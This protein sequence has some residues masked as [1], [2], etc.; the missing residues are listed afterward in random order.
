MINVLFLCLGNICR[1]PM[2]EAIFRQTVKEKGVED[3]ILIDSA[4]L[5]DWHIGHPPHEGTR[6][7]LDEANISYEGQKARQ[8][9]ESDLEKF[10]Y[11]IAMDQQNIDDLQ[12]FHFDPEKV[13][14]KRLMEFVDDAKEINVPDPYFTKNFDYTFELVKEGCEHFFQYLDQKHHILT[15]E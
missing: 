1:S 4:G 7:K 13:T 12:Q 11:V 5:G 6:G 3:Q 15:K 10:D 14:V 8:I 9:I 2:A